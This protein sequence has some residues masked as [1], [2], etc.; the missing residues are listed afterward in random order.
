[1]DDDPEDVATAERLDGLDP[2]RHLRRDEQIAPAQPAS[3]H[4]QLTRLVF[5]SGANVGRDDSRQQPQQ[6]GAEMT[7]HVLLRVDASP[8]CGGLAWPAGEVLASYLVR[9]GSAAIAHRSVL[10]LGSGTGL[11][12]L[13]AAS[14]GATVAITDQAPLLDIM[15]A[16]VALNNL[17]DRVHVFEY[18]WGMPKPDA[19]PVHPD[20]ILAADCV[21]FEPAFPLLVTTLCDL[22]AHGDPEILFCYKKRRKADKRFFTLLKKHFNWKQVED[23]PDFATYTREAISLLRLTKRR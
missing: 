8:G 7:V 12:G 17:A 10:E 21:Y 14:L 5:P 19:L 4:N 22:S 1:M 16:N 18:N 23:D 11:V 9:R 20:L 13:V 6:H 2:L 3:V 15:R